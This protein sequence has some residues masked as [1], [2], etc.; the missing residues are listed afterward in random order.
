MKVTAH[1]ADSRHATP[2][3]C[4]RTTQRGNDFYNEVTSSSTHCNCLPQRPLESAAAAAAADRSAQLK[5]LCRRVSDGLY[6]I[7]RMSARSPS[8]SVRV[9]PH[10]FRRRPPA[11]PSAA[12]RVP[13]NESTLIDA[14]FRSA[15]R[16]VGHT[17]VAKRRVES[18]GFLMNA[19]IG[20][21]QETHSAERQ[22]R[23]P[24]WAS[25]PF[26]ARLTAHNTS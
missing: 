5:P 18:P 16:V 15:E 17:Y 8:V 11:R 22:G 3:G 19:L 9:R 26:L 20:A 1:G 23:S 13:G 10:C 25:P 4:C 24:T 12:R 2:S 21:R 7:I 6:H 14:R